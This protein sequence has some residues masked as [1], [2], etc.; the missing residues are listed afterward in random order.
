MET[1]LILHTMIFSKHVYKA[2][3][4]YIRKCGSATLNT[5]VTSSHLIGSQTI[6]WFYQ[7]LG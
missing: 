1:E 6:P 2:V 4:S 7:K 5:L 3:L